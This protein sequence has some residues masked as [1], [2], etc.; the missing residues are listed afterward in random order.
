MRFRGI[1]LAQGMKAAVAAA[2]LATGLCPAAEYEP[3]AVREVSRPSCELSLVVDMGREVEVDGIRLVS[4]PN[5]WISR[6]PWWM[7]V[8]AC[9]DPAGEWLVAQLAEGQ[10]MKP[11]FCAESQF[12]TWPKRK[13]RY[14][15]LDVLESGWRGVLRTGMYSDWGEWHVRDL[16]GIPRNS[17]NEAAQPTFAEIRLFD[18]RPDDFPGWNAHPDRA[19]PEC[20][21]KK[22]WLLQ[23]F[24]FDGFWQA[25]LTNG[26]AY[27]EACAARRRRRLAK[28]AKTCPS[29]VYVKHYTISG[30]A[31]LS[32]NAQGTDECICVHPAN[33]RKGGQLCLLTV[34]P[35]GSV[36][37]EVLLDRPEGC[38]RDPD[39]SF[40]GKTVVFAMRETFAKDEAEL[41]WKRRPSAHMTRP[42]GDDYHLYALDLETRRLRQ[43]TFS[44]PYPCA[45]FE[46]CWLSDGRIAF[47]STRCVQVIP[48]HRNEN[49][50][51][52]VCDADG[53]NIRRLGYD[54]GSTL[55]PQELPD[56]RILY[57]RYE[58]NDRCARLQQ[59]L[60][61]MNP[62]GTMQTEYYGNNSIFPTSLIHFRP[63]PGTKKVIGVVSGHHVA[64]KGKLAILD[65]SV[66]RQGDGGLTFVAGSD[67]LE[68]PGV[69]PSDYDRNPVFL[70]ARAESDPFVDDFATQHGAQWQYPYPLSED[71]WLVTFLPE[72]TIRGSKC[73][74]GPNFGV[75]WQN[76]AGERELLAYDP[77]I[78]CSQ[79]VP[80]RPRRPAARRRLQKTDPNAAWGTYYVQDVYVGEPM[81]GVKRGTV[82]KLRVCA[83]EN[84]PMFLYN[85]SMYAPHDACFSKY[86]GYYGD[87]SGEGIGVR[88]CTWDVKHVLGEVDVAADGSCAFE[89]PAGNPVFFQLLDAE[90]RCVQTMRSWSTLMPG[91]FNSCIGCHENKF[92]SAAPV[93]SAALKVQRLKPAPGQGAH[94]LLRRLDEGGRL[95]SAANLLGVNAARSADPQAPTEGFSYRRLI[96]PILDR[97]CVKCHDGSEAGRPDL[98]D[99]LVPDP[100]QL[101]S[102]PSRPIDA[103]RDFTMSYWNLTAQGRQTPRLNWYSSTGVSTMLPPY[104][105][106]SARSGIMTFLTPAHHGV[107]T[108]E[109]DRRLFACWIDLG[110]PFGGSYAEATRWNAED[111]KVFD[112]H[113]R[114][115]MAFAE[116]E[117]QSLAKGRDKTTALSGG[118]VK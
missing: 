14:L 10:R 60:F 33:W 108:T 107:K 50:N 64:Q 5:R 79:P 62:D 46:P 25:S 24:G 76:V 103:H 59:P 65:N 4:D 8:F 113:Q 115:R 105:M 93:A 81:K 83:V 84:R 97:S 40:D 61:T 98:T 100:R 34:R 28:L 63:L 71:D 74:D 55:F 90:G 39:V 80:V 56:G 118:N 47:Q 35:D 82:K 99:R 111:V 37:N 94:P 7:R 12:L 21:L 88:G 87:N 3:V 36:A 11:A 22:D 49:S 89:A 2:V 110:I 1:F 18:E 114:K 101:A 77:E 15:R 109:T 32:G 91:E 66:A 26:P 86:I 42:N 73:G 38:I 45:D 27:Y 75:Y 104:A 29:I 30:D 44:E 78:E 19:Y 116:A 31:E 52:Y 9:E 43:L 51:L 106:G 13:V 102:N 112:Y 58:Y 72:G 85:G 69:V 92:E 57:T 41:C 67:I 68:R 16:F 70:K 6:S 117:R 17:K 48:C 96:Q 23:D 95:A 53:G 20:R 54:G